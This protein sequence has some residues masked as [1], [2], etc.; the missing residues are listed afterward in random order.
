VSD[1]LNAERLLEIVRHIESIERPEEIAWIVPNGFCDSILRM[2]EI[3]RVAISGVDLSG[4]M[5]IESAFVDRPRPVPKWVV[6][7]QFF[8]LGQITPPSEAAK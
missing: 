1:R 4:V 6:T 7:G 8:D 3:E 2:T 5:V